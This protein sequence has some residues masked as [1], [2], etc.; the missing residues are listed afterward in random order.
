M[1]VRD[2]I[3]RQSKLLLE[4]WM[5]NLEDEDYDGEEMRKRNKFYIP[6]VQVP[7]TLVKRG[8][9]SYYSPPRGIVPE[10]REEQ[11]IRIRVDEETDSIIQRLPAE[12]C[13]D[14]DYSQEPEIDERK[15]EVKNTGRKFK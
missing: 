9:K 13:D 10:L 5:A 3:G 12:C 14:S 15:M 8:R 1:R 2:E 7:F 6:C 4:N 11:D